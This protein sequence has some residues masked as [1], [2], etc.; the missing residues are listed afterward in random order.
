MIC[1]KG[2]E[3]NWEREPPGDPQDLPEGYQT[4]PCENCCI[5]M[6]NHSTDNC[7]HPE[8]CN[9]G[10]RFTLARN[11][12]YLTRDEPYITRVRA[13]RRRYLNGITEIEELCPICNWFVMRD[14]EGIVKYH[15]PEECLKNCQVVL[16]E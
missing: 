11:K 1:R 8:C 6:P 14:V 2:S 12:P 7:S 3:G 10:V 16:N 5:I 15:D 13:S 9:Y 4:S